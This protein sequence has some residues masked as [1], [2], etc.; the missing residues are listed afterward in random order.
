MNSR[1]TKQL[2]IVGVVE[3]FDNGE[4]VTIVTSSA[5]IHLPKQVK[6]SLTIE[7]NGVVIVDLF[8]G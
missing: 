1:K 5:A 6:H 3:I 7:S 4:F 8:E 2:R